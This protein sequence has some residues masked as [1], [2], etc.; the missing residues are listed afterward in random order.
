MSALLTDLLAVLPTFI[1]GCIAA[2]IAYQQWQTNRRKLELDLYD[3]RLRLYQATTKYISMVLTDL[4]PK[5]EDLS[6]FRRAT[7]EA[8]FLFGPDI[9]A[10]LDELFEHGVELRKWA[11]QYRDYTQS[12]PPGY[13]HK[14]VTDGA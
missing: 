1:V 11:E 12:T 5:L 7:A 2:Y 6:E 10:Y 4:K 14:K 3:R 13:D 9:R 8:D